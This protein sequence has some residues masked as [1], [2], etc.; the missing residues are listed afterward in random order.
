MAWSA[1]CDLRHSEDS[2]REALLSTGFGPMVTSTSD[3]RQNCTDVAA[4][5]SLYECKASPDLMATFEKG[6][7]K[8]LCS[9]N[10]VL[11][12]YGE[13]GKCVY[14]VVAGDVDLFLPLSS[15]QDEM[16]FRAQPGSFVGLPAAFSNEPYSMTAKAREGAQVAVM[17]R[18]KFCNL[19]ASSPALALDVLRILAA[20]TRAARIAIV[21]AGAA[22]PGH[23]Q[24]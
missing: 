2:S 18:D 14:L 21:E 19:I 5:G 17:G 7:V 8:I 23:P 11:F 3:N 13:P 16:A 24:R 6:A 9:A 22:R 20:E 15:G 4:E 1:G 12:N 10:E